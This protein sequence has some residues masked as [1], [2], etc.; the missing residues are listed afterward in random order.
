MDFEK[1]LELVKNVGEEIITEQ[2]LRQL[3]ETNNHPLAYDG[4]EPSGTAHIAMAVFRA[5]NLEDMMK[6][7]IK[8]KLWLAD[9]FAWIN[10]K[11]DGNLEK[12]KFAGEYFIEVWKAAG[13]DMSKVDVM[14]ASDAMDNKEYWKKVILVAKNT[15]LNRAQRATSIMG[16]TLG[17]L[18]ETSQLFY[19]MMQTADVFW[20]DV[21]ICQLGLDQRRANILA[22]EVSEKLK[23]KKPVVV[24]HHMIMGLQGMKQA[25]GYDENQRFDVQISSKMSKSKP[26]TAIFIHDSAEEIKR[27]IA[28]SFCPERIVEN[29]PILEFNKYIIFRKIKSLRIERPKKFG[30]DLEVNSYSELEKLFSE[31]KIHPLDLKNSTAESLDEILKPIREHFEKNKK[32]REL[33]ELVKEARITR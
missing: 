1:R 30:G 2:E 23:W 26:D 7:G 32:A 4:F 9:W 31:G 17:E 3:L 14:W 25:E 15:T 28:N 12:I 10:N 33:Y 24:S 5:I 18:K 8:F 21:D 29:N 20:L 27:K 22:R 6:A 11:M 13:V 19:P 16:R